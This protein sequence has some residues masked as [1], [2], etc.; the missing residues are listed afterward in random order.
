MKII[1]WS[2]CCKC[3]L[4][5]VF[6]T[7]LTE[8]PMRHTI[9]IYGTQIYTTKTCRRNVLSIYRTGNFITNH[10]LWSITHKPNGKT[11]RLLRQVQYGFS[12]QCFSTGRKSPDGIT[13][14]VLPSL[15]IHHRNRSVCQFPPND[16]TVGRSQNGNINK[17]TGN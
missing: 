2:K 3:L 17:E 13:H 7:V 6:E 9:T 1:V 4:Y 12:N 8:S 14:F 16:I 15:S 11:G 10:D 5:G